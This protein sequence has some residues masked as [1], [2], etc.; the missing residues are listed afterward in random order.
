MISRILLAVDDSPAALTAAS[1]AVDLAK[2][3]AASLL[4]VNVVH[5]HVLS[6]VL[7]ERA[8]DPGIETRR[9][10][11]ATAVLKHVAH[12]AEQ[13]GV[14]LEA[15]RLEGEAARNILMVAREWH[16][17]LV[18]IGQSGQRGPGE[19]YVGSETAHVLEF[20]EQPVMVVPP[21]RR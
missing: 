18:V 14:T 9:E 20:A 2:Q 12:V 5:D 8:Q 17:D 15:R 3:M 10:S 13:H 19:P 21:S 11:A 1:V 16:A 6:A 7:A 4:A